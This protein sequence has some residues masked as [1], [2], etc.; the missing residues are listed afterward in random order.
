M[1][2]QLQLPKEVIWLL[3]LLVI[4]VVGWEVIH[5]HR[6]LEKISVLGAEFIFGETDNLS[7][8]APLVHQNLLVSDYHEMYYK[9]QNLFGA[10]IALDDSVPAA[11]A[12]LPTG[13]IIINHEIKAT[14]GNSNNTSMASTNE[15]MSAGTRIDLSG[16]KDE[17]LI[18]YATNITGEVQLIPTSKPKQNFAVWKWYVTP[19]KMDESLTLF[20]EAYTVDDKGHRMSINSTKKEIDVIAI[21]TPGAEEVAFEAKDEAAVAAEEKVNETAEAAKEAAPG[22][23][24]I[25]AITGLLAV[26]YLVLGRRH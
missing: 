11:Q 20:I 4:G 19:L 10:S 15:P 12:A 2:D 26:A 3:V 6:T 22:F 14:F 23:E 17:F 24:G 1:G 8:R 7:I 25:F 5:E 13:N 21:P 18:E 16:R 9:K